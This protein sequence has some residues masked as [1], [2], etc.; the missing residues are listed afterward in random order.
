MKT[1]RTLLALA[2]AAPAMLAGCGAHDSFVQTDDFALGRVVVYRNGIAYYERRARAVDDQLTLTVPQDKVDDFLKSLTVTDA[3]TGK[4]VPVG[5]PTQGASHGSDVDMKVTLPPGTHGELVLTYITDAPAWKP[6]YRVLVEDE[7]VAVQGWA[8]V[9]NTSGEDWT[10]VRV[11]V[12][13]SS[14]LSFRYDLRSVVYVHR[15]LLGG[16]Q[17]FAQAPPP[18]GAVHPSGATEQKDRMV[19]ALGDA[20]LAPTDKAEDE[21]RV[22]EATVATLDDLGP[23]AARKSTAGGLPMTRGGTDASAAPSVPDARL[24]ALANHLRGR[25]DQVTIDGFAGPGEPA[26][27]AAERANRVRNRLIELG[28]APD[29]VQIQPRG[30]VAGKNAGVE[31]RVARAEVADAPAGPDTPVGESHFE[32][33]TP[34]TIPRGTSAMVA[35]LD[36]PAEGAVVYLYAPDAERGD[37]RYAFKAVRFRNPTKSTLEAGPVT[38]YGDARFIG[39]GLTES[40]PPESTALVPF[41]LDRQVVIERAVATQDRIARIE[42]VERGELTAEVRRVERTELNVTNRSHAAQRVFLRHR[43]ADGWKLERS[44]DVF[45]KQGEVHLFAVD[46]PAGETRTV[47]LEASTP[48]TRTVD[49]R[50]PAG[51]DLLRAHVADKPGDAAFARAAE[52]VLRLHD[53]MAEARERIDAL[54]A[55]SGQLRARSDELTGQIHSLAHARAGDRL[56]GHLEKKL[57]ELADRLQATTVEIVD[58]QEKLMLAR[59]RFQDAIAELTIG[60]PAVAN[61]LPSE[62][63]EG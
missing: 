29:R 30:L 39:E 55:Q 63:A 57:A 60:R 35:V 27:R 23:R 18:G 42:R 36:A 49:L 8:I 4:T 25:K 12:G 10:Q 59:I 33:D 16:Q 46:V 44:P 48:L 47:A 61:R 40:I 56:K 41:A 32:S 13:A 34:M 51:V 31:V 62:A 7:K 24:Q 3:E 14:A 28:V 43:V 50:T 5:Y 9:D 2:L 45:E 58:Q 11:G 19:L 53:T 52:D 21:E 17:V 1:L 38:V 54:H 26:H 20:E 37:A 15:D 6:S 22:A